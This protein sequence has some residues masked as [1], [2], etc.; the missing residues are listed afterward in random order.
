MKSLTSVQRRILNE[1]DRDFRNRRRRA[2]S[3][4]YDVDSRIAYYYDLMRRGLAKPFDIAA[5][6]TLMDPTAMEIQ[7]RENSHETIEIDDIV[8]EL[9]RQDDINVYRKFFDALSMP[10]RPDW[11]VGVWYPSQQLNRLVN[12][13]AISRNSEEWDWDNEDARQRRED[14]VSDTLN[15][16][17]MNGG[18]ERVRDALLMIMLSPA[19]K[20]FQKPLDKHGNPA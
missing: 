14:I 9:V 7:R 19:L 5:A 1:M 8:R 18:Y 20:K 17:V 10:Y 12:A 11:N 13:H 2:A 4:D 6:A 15:T 3:S 16:L